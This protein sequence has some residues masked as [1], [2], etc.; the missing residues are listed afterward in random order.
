MGR[1]GQNRSK[2]S[3]RSRYASEEQRISNRSGK[4]GTK[5]LTIGLL[6]I[7]AA[8]GGYFLVK[9]S[10]GLLS[11]DSLVT[12]LLDK[13]LSKHP[14]V[15]EEK[16]LIESQPQKESTATELHL[17]E[18]S[19]LPQDDVLPELDS[20]DDSVRDTLIAITPDIAPYLTTGQI[21]RKY[22]QM[23]NDFSQ[24][25][26]VA[27]HF[28]F[29]KLTEPFSVQ[30]NQGK[31]TVSAKSFQRYDGL[32]K[33][34]AAI[35]VSEWL[36]VY[37]RF[38]PLM[39]QVFAEFSYPDGHNLD[40]IFIG[41]AKQVLSAPVIDKPIEVVKQS[42]LYKYADPQLEALNPVHKQM[43][44]MGASNARLIQNKMSELMEGLVNPRVE[45]SPS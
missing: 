37:K 6:I 8:V 24:G 23:A 20:S 26:R 31:L 30:D 9:L 11:S 22:M 21:I 28:S 5:Y 44:R 27:K 12:S 18:I 2:K 33:A 29:L 3:G 32:A 25:T 39:L 34:I 43:L 38:R 36:A 19:N 14:P 40:S 41:A 16:Q 7:A 45:E 13:S 10:E 4:S 15:K 42:V 1:Y 35:N 17:T